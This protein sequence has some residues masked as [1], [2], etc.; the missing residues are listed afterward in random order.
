MSARSNQKI[1][2]RWDSEK[3]TEMVLMALSNRH[4]IAKIVRR[5]GV[6]EKELIEW[7]TI[8]KCAGYLALCQEARQMHLVIG[9]RVLLANNSPI[10]PE[11][12]VAPAP[13]V[14]GYLVQEPLSSD[15]KRRWGVIFD[16]YSLLENHCLIWRIPEASLKLYRKENFNEMYSDCDEVADNS[17]I[18]SINPSPIKSQDKQHA[19]TDQAA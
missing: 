1:S 6:S 8:F 3:K 2:T 19:I 13:G 9:Q 5:Y 16:D 15:K 17:K 4:S 10:D 12:G 18:Y 11:G 14:R 7:I